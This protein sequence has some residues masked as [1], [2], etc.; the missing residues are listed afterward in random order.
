MAIEKT[1]YV[2]KSGYNNILVTQRGSVRTLWSPRDVKQTEIDMNN[3]HVPNLEYARNMLLSLAF[4]PNAI[5]IAV[6][7][8]GGGSIPLALLNIL[9]GC[10][11]DVVEI[12]EE[13]VYVAREFFNLPVS[14]R[15]SLVIDDAY[16]FLSNCGERYDAIILD[17]YIGRTMSEKIPTDDFLHK[18]ALRLA[19]GGVLAVNLMSSDSKIYYDTLWT[20]GLN[21]NH[22]W[23]IECEC[24]RNVIVF[25]GRSKITPFSLAMN[26]QTIEQA[27]A[28]N[29]R[30]NIG[31]A[32]GQN[33]SKTIRQSPPGTFKPSTLV[34]R[35]TYH[36]F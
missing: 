13:M 21:F 11:I 29:I 2:K 4:V 18:T 35:L 31:Q 8:L 34:H 17:A 7:G 5:S 9:G 30:Q 27:I 3:P 23:T 25:A 19:D 10:S 1:L 12:D 33:N 20:I 22:L 6:M 32:I 36:G 24:S 26:A 16:H 28:Q 14:P 15:L